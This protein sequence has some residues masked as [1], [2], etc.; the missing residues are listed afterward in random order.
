MNVALER[1]FPVP[2]SQYNPSLTSLSFQFT[3][4]FS[5]RQLTIRW[6]FRIRARAAVRFSASAPKGGRR[7]CLIL[8]HRA[9]PAVERWGYFWGY[10]PVTKCD[11]PST[12]IPPSTL[13]NSRSAE[14]ERIDS[15][16][17]RIHTA[18]PLETLTTG[19]FAAPSSKSGDTGLVIATHRRP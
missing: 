4:L 17:Q 16:R 8:L 1:L 14:G 2:G 11:T 9:F 12:D 7:R 5:R 6:P 13:P 3:A 15:D 19:S 18:D 10:R